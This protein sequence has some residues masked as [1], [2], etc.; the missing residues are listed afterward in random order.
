[1]LDKQKKLICSE[2]AAG[3]DCVPFNVYDEAADEVLRLLY[4][5][6]FKNFAKRVA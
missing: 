6:S 2:M 3:T 5:N 1:M 4:L